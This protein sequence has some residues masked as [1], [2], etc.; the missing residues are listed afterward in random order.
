ME[1]SIRALEEQLRHLEEEISANETALAALLRMKG[2]LEGLQTWIEKEIGFELCDMENI[3]RLQDENV[4]ENLK[5]E[6]F[7]RASDKILSLSRT[8]L[9]CICTLSS[10]SCCLKF[11]ILSSGQRSDY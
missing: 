4:D 6:S 5:R 9:S 11:S 8:M 10:P 2:Q 1:N 3:R 7:L